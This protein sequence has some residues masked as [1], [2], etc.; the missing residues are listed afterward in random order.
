MD[1]ELDSY[2]SKPG[3]K[4]MPLS[5][6]IDNREQVINTMTKLANDPRFVKSRE[7]LLEFGNERFL[8][9]DNFKEDFPPL[10]TG[11]YSS[12]QAL[13]LARFVAIRYFIKHEPNFIRKIGPGNFLPECVSSQFA[14]SLLIFYKY[15]I[16]EQLP[17]ESDFF[18][19]VHLSYLAYI[20]NYVTE[21]NVSNVINHIKST[22]SYFTD[23]KAMNISEFVNSVLSP[24]Q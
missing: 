9:L 24:R 19:F 4:C 20:D 13:D 1:S 11:K 8:S 16:H 23:V 21:K 22:S 14:G 2:P 18:D 12:D 10:D 15:Y 5:A 7:I 17:M 3:A 6:H